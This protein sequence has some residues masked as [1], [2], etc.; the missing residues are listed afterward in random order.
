MDWTNRNKK[1]I[2]IRKLPPLI[3]RTR[4]TFYST[5]QLHSEWTK[6]F[7]C[8]R[9]QLGPVTIGPDMRWYPHLTF[10][11]SVWK[12][13]LRVLIRSAPMRRFYWVPQNMVLWRNKKISIHF[14]WKKNELSGV[15]FNIYGQ[16]TKP[17]SR[18]SNFVGWPVLCCSILL[19]HVYAQMTRGSNVKFHFWRKVSFTFYFNA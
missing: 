16:K 19:V 10:L 15:Q 18:L 11:I 9:G 14:C 4:N 6:C 5:I 13:M 1:K 2:S 7:R 12:H 3:K 8:L 17:L